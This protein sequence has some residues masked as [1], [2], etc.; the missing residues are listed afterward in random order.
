M[1]ETKILNQKTNGFSKFCAWVVVLSPLLDAYYLP[2][3]TTLISTAVLFVAAFT[4]LFF[5]YPRRFQLPQSYKWFII[6]ALLVPTINQLVNFPIS[7]IKSSLIAVGYYTFCLG[8]ILPCIEWKDMIKAYKI[9]VLIAVAVFLLQEVCFMTIGRRFSALIPFLTVR[10]DGVGMTEFMINQ[11]LSARSSSLFLEPAHFAQYIGPFLAIL[12]GQANDKKK[13]VYLP[14]ILFSLI[15]FFTKSGNGIFVLAVCWAFFI[16]TYKMS[17]KMKLLILIPF[18]A[19]AGFILFDIIAETEIGQQL[20]SRKDELVIGGTN[21]VSS[22]NVRI[23]RGYLVFFEEPFW[24]QLFGVGQGAIPAVIDQSRY[25]WMF[26]EERYTNVVQSLL[27]GAGYMG[28]GIF[29][30]HIIGLYK[31]NNYAGK[32]VIIVLIALSFI[33]SF[34]YG[35]KM[36]LIIMLACACQKEFYESQNNIQSKKG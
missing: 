2:G 1:T 13:V 21:W 34:L 6:Y 26:G 12:L 33:E 7:T 3:T 35:S 27:M 9:I 24:D 28:T 19:I 8:V 22:G 36:M 11:S 15:L 4:T 14:A 16:L 29:L 25:L 10:Y 17:F 18:S 31:S 30:M 32:C 23:S 5:N 20:L